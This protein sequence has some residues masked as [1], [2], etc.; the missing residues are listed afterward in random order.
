[1]DAAQGH[2][3]NADQIAYWNGPG[4]QRWAARQAAQDI[5]L[6]PVLDLLVDR[7]KPTA[8]ERVLD[9]GCGSGASTNALAN[10]VGPSGHVFGVD[11][12]GP[13]LERARQSTP[14]DAPVD[15]AL[16]DATVYPFDP[17]SFD[18]LTSR[19]GVMFFAEPAVSF[20]N[21]RKAL[22]RSARLAFACW[23]E[24]RENPFFMTSLQAVYKHVPKL[25]QLGPEDPG[26]FSFASEA[27][28][29]RILGEAGFS[30]IAMEP[31][32]LE[33]DV[34]IGRGL[35][36]AVQGAL[37]IGPASRALEGHPDD[38]R[39]AAITSIR[40]ALTPFAKGDSVL[41]PAAIWIVTARA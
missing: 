26:P 3:R 16:A 30:G 18:L 1:M 9:V 25:P 8:G 37:E 11:V 38:V 14:Q 5:V 12:S 40:E 4:G 21:L 36:A 34:A 2:E 33:L 20:A 10:K 6:K 24:P 27:R 28:V 23:K 29:N 39:A 7:A 41:L 19:F 31:C 35:D 13:M 22:K 32:R 17:A 15:Y